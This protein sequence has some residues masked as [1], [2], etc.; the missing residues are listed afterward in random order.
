MADDELQEVGV[1]IDFTGPFTANELVQI[2]ELGIS[3]D[4]ISRGSTGR[5][6]RAVAWVIGRRTNPKLTLEQAGEVWVNL[7]G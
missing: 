3:L 6:I 1:E 4:E 7:D 2:G 5:A